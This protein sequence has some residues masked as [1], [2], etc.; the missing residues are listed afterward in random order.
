MS[1]ALLKIIERK[2]PVSEKSIGFR[3]Q[4]AVPNSAARDF[5]GNA[6]PSFA[7]R[8]LIAESSDYTTVGKPEL[9]RFLDELAF[10]NFDDFVIVS[11]ARAT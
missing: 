4:A 1:Q 7:K 9:E 5:R 11:D 3:I 8:Y 10:Q 6:Q 2:H